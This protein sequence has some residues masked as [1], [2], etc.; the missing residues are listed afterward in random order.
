M[1]KYKGSRK[2][3]TTLSLV[4][5]KYCMVRPDGILPLYQGVWSC[6]GRW[7]YLFYA[8]S[9]CICRNLIGIPFSFLGPPQTNLRRLFRLQFIC[10]N[11]TVESLLLLQIRPISSFEKSSS[12]EEE[13]LYRSATAQHVHPSVDFLR[14][15]SHLLTVQSCMWSYVAYE[16]CTVLC[17]TW[18]KRVPVKTYFKFH[19]SSGCSSF[20]F[21]FNHFPQQYQGCDRQALCTYSISLPEKISKKA[22][23]LTRCFVLLRFLLL[24]FLLLF[25]VVAVTAFVCCFALQTSTTW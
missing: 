23:F 21:Q 6:L 19:H 5:R 18:W 7:L 1:T 25:F 2:K 8:W 4:R 22:I 10:S 14:H 3:S 17:F 16:I 13:T 24:V 12:Y 20:D 15:I 9:P 11:R